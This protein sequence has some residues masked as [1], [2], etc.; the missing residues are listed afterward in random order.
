MAQPLAPDGSWL[1]AVPH[2]QR[3]RQLIFGPAPR[4]SKISDDRGES[5]DAIEADVPR[6]NIRSAPASAPTLP[7]L[8]IPVAK[9][10]SKVTELARGQITHTETI[11]VE[12]IEADETSAGSDHQMASKASM[13][14]P[15]RLPSAADNAARTFAAAAVK[16]AQIKRVRKL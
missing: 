7:G 8:E 1:L 15:Q 14:H 10:M 9:S 6:P 16:L 11:T 4:S 5:V 13:I 12:L 3:D 2:S